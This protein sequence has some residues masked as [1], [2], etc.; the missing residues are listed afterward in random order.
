M[1]IRSWLTYQGSSIRGTLAN[2]VSNTK[3][4]KRADDLL[5]TYTMKYVA[6]A[7]H[8][9]DDFDRFAAR[10]PK[11][12]AAD[13]MLVRLLRFA[14][15]RSPIMGEVPISRDRWGP[16][17]LR[18]DQSDVSKRDGEVVFDAM[19]E[20]RIIVEATPEAR[21]ERIRMALALVHYEPSVDASGC[22]TGY[23]SRDVPGGASGS[24]P[25]PPP[26]PPD[27]K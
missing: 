10:I 4:G 9:D 17:V 25:P 11:R 2:R 27:L 18:T 22:V 14:A 15:D 21:L 13:A 12:L 3:K 20:E 19:L 16:V 23:V 24:A 6:V 1:L 5:A 26:P 8:F 7:T